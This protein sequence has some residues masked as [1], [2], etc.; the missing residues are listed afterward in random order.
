M[1]T[2]NLGINVRPPIT[3]DDVERLDYFLRLTALK[4]KL[5]NCIQALETTEA[6]AC[7][8]IESKMN[9]KA[10]RFELFVQ[11]RSTV[12]LIKNFRL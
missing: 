1:H 4:L 11:Y 9:S 10:E 3:D 7:T 2:W 5:E 12:E 6:M 8:S